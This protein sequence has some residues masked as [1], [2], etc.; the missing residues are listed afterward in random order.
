MDH[1]FSLIV[2]YGNDNRTTEAKNN[3]PEMKDSAEDFPYEEMKII[4]KEKILSDEDYPTLF[5]TAWNEE[6]GEPEKCCCQI[7]S[8]YNLVHLTQFFQRPSI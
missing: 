6:K 1:I 8:Q 2:A 4:E 5:L 7:L 3:A